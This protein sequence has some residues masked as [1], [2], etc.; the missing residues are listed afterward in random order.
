MV[1][2]PDISDELLSALSAYLPR[3][4][5]IL[6]AGCGPGLYAQKLKKINDNILGLDLTDIHEKTKNEIPFCLGSIT[7]LPIKTNSI[8]FIYCLTVLQYIEDDAQAIHE[9]YRILK[10]KGK[11]FI[12]VP[13]RWSPFW[14]IRETEIYCGVYPWQSSWNIRPYHYYSRSMIGKLTENKFSILEISGYLY[15]F[16]PRLGGIFLNLAKKNRHF[17]HFFSELLLFRQRNATIQT[18]SDTPEPK[19]IETKKNQPRKRHISKIS[20]LSYHYLIVLEK[21]G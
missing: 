2:S 13:T 16:F 17:N 4:G 8:D 11:L 6:D 1:S 18:S 12:T 14:L 15:N 20:D 19:V 5:K 9:F 3:E 10:P 21:Q 7:S